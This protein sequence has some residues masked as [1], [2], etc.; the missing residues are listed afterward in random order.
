M[1]IFFVVGEPPNLARIAALTRETRRYPSMVPIVV[2]AGNDHDTRL[3]DGGFEELAI[4]PPDFT[5]G[6][7]PGSHAVQTAEVMTRLEPLLEAMRPDLVLVVGDADTTA[8]A[9]LTASKLEIAVAHVDAGLR[10]F[11]RRLPEE[12]NALRL[13]EQKIL[14]Y[15]PD[16]VTVYV[17]WNDL[18]KRDPMS[19]HQASS[20]R[21]Q[22]LAYRTYDVYLIKLW[23]KVVYAKL[24]PLVLSVG[25]EVPPDEAAAY[26]RYVPTVFMQHLERMAELAKRHHARMVFLTLP[27]PLRADMDPRDVKRLYFPHYTYNLKRFALGYARYNQVIKDVAKA[28]GIPVIDLAARF[29]DRGNLFMDT[30]HAWCVGHVALAAEIYRGLLESEILPA[31][32]HALL[33]NSQAAQTTPEARG[34]PAAARVH[35]ARHLARVELAAGP[36]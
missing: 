13:L 8:A 4:Q 19:I 11:D 18:V 33:K 30:A 14:H 6:I 22:W 26:A 9:T 2:Y 12:I 31:R 35:P 16:V 7:G 10:S 34:R 24:R 20:E 32:P 27:S 29:A 15:Q 5:L 17:G 25:R 3:G 1:R 36:L 28:E 23:R 21:Y